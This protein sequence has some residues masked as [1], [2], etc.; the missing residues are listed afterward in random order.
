MPFQVANQAVSCH[1]LHSLTLSI[2]TVVEVSFNS[3][4]QGHPSESQTH[5]CFYLLPRISCLWIHTPR[6]CPWPDQTV[7]NAAPQITD[8]TQTKTKF[9]CNSQHNEFQHY[10]FNIMHSTIMHS[11][12]STLSM[13]I[14]PLWHYA[15][16]NCFVQQQFNNNV[17]SKYFS[18]NKHFKIILFQ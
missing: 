2:T 5:L 9:D 18:I 16:T 13:N 17:L 8:P 3:S 4:N 15:P 14:Y 7:T 6:P 10:A 1:H 11:T 12:I